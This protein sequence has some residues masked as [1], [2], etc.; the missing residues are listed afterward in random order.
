[1]DIHETVLMTTLA[2][3]WARHC[4]QKLGRTNMSVAL[5]HVFIC[6]EEGGPE[7]QMFLDIGLVEG[8]RN[9]HPGQGTANRRFFFHGGFIELLWIHNAVEAQSIL[10]APTRLW[11]RWSDRERGA[12]PFGI[13]FSPTGDEVP[14]PPFSAWPYRPIYLPA[15][16]E[17]L[18]AE[19]TALSEPELFYLAWP[20]PQE[21]SRSQRMDHPNGMLRLNAASVGLPLSTSLSA[22][23]LAVQSAG[24]LTFHLADRCEL[25]LSF[26]GRDTACFD[27]RPSIPLVLSTSR[28]A[29]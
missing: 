8:T 5:D 12:C 19:G 29:A 21:S 24:L 18:F 13:A 2:H 14:S 6:C 25:R 4:R 1:M 11:P 20:N 17:I 10:T 15:S 3:T 28:S 23:S 27:L 16:K 7:A 26:E 22:S 9:I